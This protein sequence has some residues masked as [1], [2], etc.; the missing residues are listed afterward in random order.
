V[1][2]KTESHIRT[3]P[4][5]RLET[6]KEEGLKAHQG[7]PKSGRPNWRKILIFSTRQMWEKLKKRKRV[8][9]PKDG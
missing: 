4:R 3:T 5:Q 9:G 6:G 8:N 2:G 7:S 1:E